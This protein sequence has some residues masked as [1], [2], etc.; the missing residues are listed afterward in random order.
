MRT[1]QLYKKI[2]LLA[3]I[4]II[5]VAVL[6]IVLVVKKY[7]TPD[8]Q[9]AVAGIPVGNKVS[10]PDVDWAKNGRT[11]L[12]VLQKDCHFCT[13]SAPFYQRLVRETAEQ[14][15]VRLIAALPNT[16]DESKQ[17]L[18]N[19]GVS[20]DEVKQ[21]SLNSIGVEGTPTLILVDGTG[22]IE[23]SWVGQ[24]PPDKEAEVL[25]RLQINKVSN[26]VN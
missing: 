24:L 18:S 12:L 1:S 20:I 26:W 21:A 15:N 9:E 13:E 10:M 4:A 17:Y 7:I 14:R 6:I 8:H 11:L 22:K 2:E 25:K 16:V 3:N 19:L 5:L 23:A